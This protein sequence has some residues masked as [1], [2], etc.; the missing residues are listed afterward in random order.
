MRETTNPISIRQLYPDLTDE[1]LETAEDNLRRYIAVMV[2][3]YERFRTEQGPEA[4]RRL[5]YGDLTESDS[6]SI[7]LN[8][9]SNTAQHH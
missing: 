6:S 8:E 9:R 1:Q 7:V 5:A 3:I 4:A 2:R